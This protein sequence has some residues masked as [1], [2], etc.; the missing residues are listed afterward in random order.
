MLLYPMTFFFVNASILLMISSSFGPRDITIS[1]IYITV[2]QLKLNIL[3][4][5]NLSHWVIGDCL[6]SVVRDTSSVKITALL[7]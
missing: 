4:D 7:Y 3:R 2:I 5:N 6:E 1:N